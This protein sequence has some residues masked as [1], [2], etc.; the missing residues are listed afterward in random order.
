MKKTDLRHNQ[1]VA[2]IKKMNQK[3]RKFE[4]RFSMSPEIYIK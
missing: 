1:E 4:L 3:L 2:Y